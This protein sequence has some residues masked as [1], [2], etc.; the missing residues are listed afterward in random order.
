M[1]TFVGFSRFDPP[2][3][4]DVSVYLMK[5]RFNVLTRSS[6]ARV[7][8]MLHGLVSSNETNPGELSSWS[9]IPTGLV[10]GSLVVNLLFLLSASILATS[11]RR[12]YYRYLVFELDSSLLTGRCDLTCSRSIRLG[13][14]MTGSGRGS[15]LRSD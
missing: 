15:C 13:L 7:A 3:F 14:I 9:G 4:V 2:C 10:T 8:S 5:L 6:L 12:R 11:L 1:R